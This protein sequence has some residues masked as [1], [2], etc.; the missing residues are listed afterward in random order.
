MY[1]KI[2]TNARQKGKKKLNARK[3][4]GDKHIKPFIHYRQFNDNV[5]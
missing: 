3:M 4:C 2:V 5:N 1:V